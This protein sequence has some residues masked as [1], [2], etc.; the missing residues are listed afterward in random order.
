MSY[1]YC[2]ADGAA[3]T[4]EGVPFTLRVG[5][6]WDA[7]DPFVLAHRGCFSETP[8]APF[9]RRTVAAPVVPEAPERR[10]GRR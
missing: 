9:P 7:S 3:D 8:P 6:V 5:D 4:S 1:V 2:T 10:R